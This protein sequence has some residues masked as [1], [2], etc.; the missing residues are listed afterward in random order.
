M[1]DIYLYILDIYMIFIFIYIPSV[2][3][4]AYAGFSTKD[5]TSETN[6]VIKFINS[7]LLWQNIGLTLKS[8]ELKRFR[9]SLK[10]HPLRVNLYIV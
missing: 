6:S 1:H 5:E 10:C 8:V 7:F 4:Y 9:M 2:Y 3:Y